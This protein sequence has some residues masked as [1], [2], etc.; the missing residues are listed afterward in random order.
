[1]YMISSSTTLQSI[2]LPVYLIY[3]MQVDYYSNFLFLAY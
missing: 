3:L 1:M 2:I